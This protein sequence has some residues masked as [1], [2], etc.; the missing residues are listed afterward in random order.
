MVKDAGIDTTQYAEG[1]LN[2]CTFDGKLYGFPTYAQ[3]MIL[4]YDSEVFEKE[5]IEVPKTMEELIE[6][7]KY[8]KEK[9]T[10]IAIP[11]KQGGASSTLFSQMLYSDGGN[12]LDDSGNLDLTSDKVV[13]VAKDYQELTKYSVEGSLAW[14]HDEVAEAVRTKAAP[15]GIVMSGLANQNADPDKSLIVDTVEYAPLAGRE[16]KAAACNTFWV[17]AVANNSVNKEAA[18]DYC[19]WMASKDIEKEQALEDQQISAITELAEDKEILE[20]APYVPVVME[21][22]ENGKGDP[23]TKGF[24][25]LKEAL[26]ASLSE[27]ASSDATP[28]EVMENLQDSMK[29]V[30]FSK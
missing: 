4:A 2:D 19:S 28:K 15:I 6:V 23:Q 24:A 25:S 26:N 30:D 1:L 22:L 20:N 16:G 11:A 9:G 21:Q 27:L 17:W 7:A 3:S 8:F 29:D 10:G 18:F 5:N 14:H 12:Y 13:Q